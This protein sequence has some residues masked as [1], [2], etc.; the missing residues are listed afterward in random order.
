MVNNQTTGILHVNDLRTIT[1]LTTDTI[2]VLIT[3]LP[4]QTQF[5]VGK[6]QMLVTVI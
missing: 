3:F 2:I 1:L 5:A 6:P 4:K